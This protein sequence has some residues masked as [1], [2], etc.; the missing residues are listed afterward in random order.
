MNKR[1]KASIFL[2]LVCIQFVLMG[3]SVMGTSSFNENEQEFPKENSSQ[4]KGLSHSSPYYFP[5]NSS[6]PLMTETS[7]GGNYDNN[8]KTS[9]NYYNNDYV[10]TLNLDKS[11]LTIGETLT[12]NVGLNCNLSASPGRVISV[13][14]YEGFYRNYYYYYSSYSETKTPIYTKILT[15]DGN[16][17]ASMTFSSTTTEGMYTVYAYT[18]DNRVYKDFT[19]GEVGIFYKGPRY[20]KTNQ[21]YRA[22]V[23]VVNL[24]DFSG[25]PLAFFN[26]SLSYYLSSTTSWHILTTDLVQTDNSGYAIFNT[27]IPL[28]ADNY[29]FLRL[30]LSTLD[31]K[32]EYQTFL[33]ESWEYYYYCMWGGEQK[34]N[35]EQYQYVVT[36]DKTIYTPG[37]NV[38]L[39]ILALQYS[40]M[41]ES[42]T[43]LRYTPI[44]LTIYNPDEFAIFWTDI[45]TDEF[46]ILSFNFPLDE[47]CDLG[48][49][50]FEF[51]YS[52]ET[53]R[54]NVKVD[55]YVKPVFRVDIDTNGKD[56]YSTHEKWFEGFIDVSYYFG[57]PVVGATVELII[58]S[59]WGEIKKVIEGYTNGE[60]R[61]YFFINLPIIPDLE[62]S[63]N[64]QAV[65]TDDYGRSASIEKIYTRI[66]ELHAYGYLTDWAPHPDD[67]LEYYFYAF[68]YV[69]SNYGRWYWNYN[70]LANVSANIEIFGIANYPIYPIV[71][72]HKKLLTTYSR[73]T[74][75]FG[76]G[77]LE[78]KLP[79]IHI[80]TYNLF[81][82]RLS[83]TLEDGRT[84]SSSYFYRYKKYS[85]D[86][87]ILE[88]SLDPGNIL[89]FEVT[90]KDVLTDSSSTGEGKIYIYDSNHQLIGRV[91]DLISGSKTYNFL[92]PSSSPEGKYFIY[93]Y[94][95]SRQDKYYGG[96]NY[97]SAHEYFIVGDFRSISFSTNFS[98][99][100]TYY[101]KIIVQLGDVIEID[102]TTNVTTN[103]QH[104]LEIYKRGILL[105]IPLEINGNKFS[106]NLSVIPEF[107]LDFTII[108]YTISDSG[109][110]YESVL[111]VHVDYD[112]GITLS[113]DKEIYE[114]GDLVTLTI[115]PTENTTSVVALSFIDSAI[116][117]VEPE[118]DSELAYFSDR[119][120]ST[121]I[122]SGCSWGS[123]FSAESY[124]WFGYGRRT[125]GIYDLEINQPPSVFADNYAGSLEYFRTVSLKSDT[126]SFDELLSN[127]ETEIRK[128]ISESAN[129]MPELVISEPTEI[130]FK[131]PD[132]IGEWTIRAVC[133]NMFENS[134]DIIL[135]GDVI[136]K[137]IKSF[138]PFF[139][140]FDIS[141]PVLQDDILSVKG[142][143][144]NYIGTDVHA[145]VAINAPE[146]IILNKD[147]QEFFIPD[148]YV[149]EVEFSVY[150]IE[151]YSQNITLLAAAEPFGVKYSDAKQLTIFIK[152]NGIEI[153]NR[154]IGFLNATDGSLILNHTI[155]PLA[156]YHKETLALYTDLMDISIDS[157]QSLIGYPYGCIEQTISK[158]LPT[159]LI[160]NYLNQTGQ[161]TS[162]LKQELTFMILDGLSR[163]YNF[164]HNDGGWGWWRNDASKIIMTSIV[165]FALNKIEDMGFQINSDILNKG[166]DYL[167]A[168]QQPNG[169]WNFQ[170]YSSNTLEATAYILNV[171]LSSKNITS[172]M[173]TAIIS[174]VEEFTN[175]W[176]SGDMKSTYSASLFYI[177]TLGS[178]YENITLNNELIQF[179]KVDKKVEEDTIYWE[180]DT[181][182]IWYWRKLGKKVEITS[183]ATLALAMDDYI[184]NYALIQKAVRFLLNSRNRWGW[185]STADTSA[186]IIALT[187]INGIM[188]NGGIIDFNGTISIVINNNTPPQYFL[189]V[190]DSNS[191][192]D[193]I[194]L[195]LSDFMI[196]N[197]NTINITLNG[198]GKICYIFESVQILRSNPKIEIPEI[199]EVSKNEHFY[200]PIEFSNIDERMPLVDTT[201]SLLDVPDNFSDPEAEYKIDYPLIV[202]GSKIYFPLV[203]PNIDG[204]YILEGVS[205][206][207]YIQYND[208]SNNSSRFQPFQRTIGPIIIRVGS[209]SQSLFPSIEPINPVIEPQIIT[210][211]KQISKTKLFYSGEVINVTLKITNNGE[212]RQFY[213]VEDEQPTGTVFLTDSVIISDNYDDTE[214]TYGLHSS[215]VHFFFPMLS[216]GI[217]E[218]SYQIQI[219][220]IKNAYSGSCKLWGMYDDILFTGKS[221][222][223][224][225]IPR[226][227]YANQFVYQDL[228]EPLIINTSIKQSYEIPDIHLQIDIDAIDNNLIN[229]IRV[230][231]SQKSGWRS[232]SL[233]SMDNQGEFSITITDLKNVNSVVTLF[234]EVT[235]IYGN[236]ATL[237][238]LPI[239]ITA[240]ELIPYLIVGVII[241][242]SV[243]LASISTILYKKSMEKKKGIKDNIDEKP[244][245]VISFLNNSEEEFE[246]SS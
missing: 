143:I 44:S 66:R 234:I 221:V 173:D 59:Y 29:H 182:S 9:Y 198:S 111:A 17:Q 167:I 119:P 38:F 211:E 55:Y 145:T 144:Y 96:F 51:S 31:G 58:K 210:I 163:I 135:W 168:H 25:L 219:N 77:K 230:V 199:I 187:E 188:I 237:I 74:N 214:I 112:F 244:K 95:Y 14:I 45:T 54:Y 133:N 39:R 52:G 105:S 73:T 171:F 70:P 130:T 46:G 216:T 236:T 48:S 200:F 20:Y 240:Y 197:P 243:G 235:D 64:V 107:V 92:I 124:W 108:I 227:H 202:N 233:Y 10:L 196:E 75:I 42:K 175:L 36:T 127:F 126:P 109:K 117:D 67:T 87:N 121:Y 11:V 190:T 222:V 159:A 160:F 56:Y 186:A 207:G 164:Q 162:N 158:T 180:S 81:E 142:Y 82:I 208:T 217:T 242:F 3:F 57:Q 53:Y 8:L 90:F 139:I 100:G 32:T 155:D 223:L 6:S 201:I 5:I 129:W 156:I 232:Q 1:R 84:T 34:S 40:F 61:F 89:E 138:L 132:N 97:H 78:F 161:L 93:S 220:S 123:G 176:N 47:D 191:H 246:I 60:G 122:S 239:K 225:N 157:W 218:I 148:G 106:Y 65:V 7:V 177:A 153:T 165:I 189:N 110:L 85:L 193:E 140:E 19:I 104:Y 80:S 4:N 149:S 23:H 18:E 28:D 30:T 131:L 115:T 103:I 147:V 205:I 183:Y 116:L 2:V 13:E 229:K 137:Q 178:I 26:Y 192:P 231:F 62:Y 154:T 241:G 43:A 120:Y 49:Y 166:I 194:L 114:P 94:V 41:N 76:S 101:D 35:Q 181:S 68:Q 134:N 128:N 88:K 98:T 203:A 136:S 141:E 213:V 27:N 170:E 63:F 238:L 91:S 146:L 71:W 22:A 50:G 169:L 72:Q 69:M 33:Y 185:G 215:G 226:K 212:S 37:D 118:D 204:D 184:N 24:T 21:E 195:K 172:Q 150:C 245:D 151:P 83:V 228:T 15:T 12:V 79:I 102:G 209:H 16:G 224:E 179:I 86:I 125:G 152:P 206:L 174:A 99:T 113:T